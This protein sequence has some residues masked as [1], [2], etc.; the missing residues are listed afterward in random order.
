MGVPAR[1]PLI[2]LNEHESRLLQRVG[3]FPLLTSCVRRSPAALHRRVRANVLP[4]V[5]VSEARPGLRIIE[6][7]P[8]HTTTH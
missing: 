1:P 4:L 6:S 2:R 5:S 7:P 8:L 3:G